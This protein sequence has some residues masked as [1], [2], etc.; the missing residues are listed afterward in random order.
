MFCNA[1]I[2]FEH[3]KP[4]VIDK[5]KLP[6]LNTGQVLIKLMVSGIC[7]SQLLEINGFKD[8]KKF[9]PHC[10]GHEGSGIVIDT[11]PKV[12]MVKKGDRVSLTWI[13]GKGLDGGATFF[14]CNNNK[15]NAGPITT[16]S[17]YTIVSENRVYPLKTNISFEDAALLGCAVPTGLG[18]ILNLLKPQENQS[19][20]IFGCGAIGLIALQ[21]AKICGCNPIIAI[22]L[23]DNKL[24]FAKEMGAKYIINAKEFSL[25]KINT[26]VKDL[27]FAVEASGSHIAMINALKAVRP[28]GGKAVI[29]GNIHYQ[30]EISINP[31]E[32]NLGKSLLGTWGGNSVPFRDYYKYEKL[33]RE[34]KLDLSFFKND[35]YTL[36]NINSAIESFSKG[37]IA[38]PLIKFY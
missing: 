18:A 5:I 3:N 21:G 4:L 26:L 10:L 32:F 16:F 29:I 7:Q 12:T 38:R 11:G 35:I 13:K 9:L 17:E 28:Q 25:E 24:Q 22:D 33:I 1:A 30:G 19:L 34:R 20:A 15:I 6:R 14:E 2:L 27:D 37:K 36:E 23:Y 31:R 8:N